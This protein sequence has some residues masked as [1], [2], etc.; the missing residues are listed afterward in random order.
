MHRSLDGEYARPFQRS[1]AVQV[2]RRRGK[3]RPRN[4]DHSGIC[5][6]D[7]VLS[8]VRRRMADHTQ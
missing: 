5:A 3:R 1:P 7:M 4:D 8:G 2:V 6:A